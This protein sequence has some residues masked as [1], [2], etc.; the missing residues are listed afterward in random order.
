MLP[1]GKNHFLENSF[2][3][4]VFDFS[5][6]KNNLFIAV[7]NLIILKNLIEIKENGAGNINRKSVNLYNKNANFSPDCSG[8]KAS[9]LPDAANSGTAESR[10]RQ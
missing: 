9:G 8:A 2:N 10:R 5:C 1:A 7:K 6:Y 3:P 4:A